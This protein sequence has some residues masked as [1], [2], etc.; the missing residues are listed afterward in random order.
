M[1]KIFIALMPF[2]LGLVGYKATAQDVVKEKKEDKKEVQEIIVRKKGEKDATVTIQFKDD[3]VIING[4]PLVEFNDN[5]ITINNRKIV[6]WDADHMLS[7]RDMEKSMQGFHFEMDKMKGMI[8]PGGSKTFLGVTTEKDEKGALIKSVVKES[9]A[10][11]AG[12]KEGDVITN[13]DKEKIGGPEDL[14]K[15]IGDKKPKE[16]VKIIYRRD[17]KEKTAKASLGERKETMV[18]SYSFTYPEGA[19][20][21]PRTPAAPGAPRPF[22]WDQEGSAFSLMSKARLGLKI[23]D[24]EDGTGV[25]VL[26]VED[27]SAA[28]KAGIKKDDIVTQIGGKTI[29]NTDEAREQLRL[30]NDSS[31]YPVVVKRNNSEMKFDIKIPKKLKTA[32]L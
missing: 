26:D 12:L 32:N 24:T 4:K 29:R 14:S 6:T 30:H 16:E 3:K 20:A 31:T 17:G 2:I 9:A 10:E 21:M 23:Q 11:K 1:N 22:V 19:P 5:D 13:I 27:G 7:L 18:K 25:K 28:E 8:A 15:I